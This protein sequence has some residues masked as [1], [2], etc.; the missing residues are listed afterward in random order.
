MVAKKKNDSA[1]ASATPGSA[2]TDETPKKDDATLPDPA[3]EAEVKEEASAAPEAKPD[4]LG[5][6]KDRLLRLQADFDNYRK[7][8]AREYLENRA[9]AHKD[10]LEAILVPMDH[11]DHAIAGL[12][13]TVG[14]NDP[15]LQGVQLVRAEFKNALEK[16]G[17]KS[18]A[19]VG[20][21]FNPERHEALGLV[22]SPEV[23]EGHVA[24]EVRA[25]YLLNDR[26]L[27]A[28][29][30]MVAKGNDK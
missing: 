20:E 2:A 28:A 25:G 15:C 3:P 18:M 4:E 9:S 17:L 29:Q 5:V 21:L 7:R 8:M 23:K 30:V 27:R 12:L 10:L 13:K 11:F 6:L 22:P 26:V 16:F 14:E 24:A 1:K 19:T